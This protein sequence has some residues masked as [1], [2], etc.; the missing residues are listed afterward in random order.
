MIV[1]LCDVDSRIV[2]W[3]LVSNET[4]VSTGDGWKLVVPPDQVVGPSCRVCLV[5]IATPVVAQERYTVVGPEDTSHGLAK[6]YS[7]RVII[8]GTASRAELA[9]IVRQVTADGAKRTY[10]RSDIASQRWGDSE[11]HVVYVY[12][13]LSAAENERFNYICRSQWIGD[14]TPEAGHP[15]QWG[16]DDVGDGV[17]LIWNEHHDFLSELVRSSARTKEDYL[18]AVVPMVD[19]LARRLQQIAADV[20]QVKAGHMQ[21]RDFA[22]Q[23]RATLQHLAELDMSHSNA[24]AAPYE[25]SELDRQVTDLL[26]HASNLNL[27]FTESTF[28][29]RTS[30]NRLSLTQ[31]S[32][33]GAL[34]AVPNVQYELGKVR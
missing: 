23:N 4:L 28:L 19:D 5:D 3:Q 27:Y 8:N 26:G 25:C 30:D 31:M 22:E 24:G 6:R 21:E 13:A 18:A 1:C 10:N 34:S 9:A 17:F 14:D 12:I 20:G 2:Y 11:A 29:E 7:Y 16:G 33:D 15:G 32:L